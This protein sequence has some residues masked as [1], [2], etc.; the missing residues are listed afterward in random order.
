VVAVTKLLDTVVSKLLDIVNA[1]TML[2]TVVSKLLD[3]VNVISMF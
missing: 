1:I 3:I 2:D